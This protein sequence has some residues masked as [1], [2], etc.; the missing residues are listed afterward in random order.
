MATPQREA[1]DLLNAV[2][3]RRPSSVT[4][5]RLPSLDASMR[6]SKAGATDLPRYFSISCDRATTLLLP[7]VMATRHVSGKALAC[8]KSINCWCV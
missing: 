5:S 1:G 6:A 8:N 3:T 2:S 7:S 4:D